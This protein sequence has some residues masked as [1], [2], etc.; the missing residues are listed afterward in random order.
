MT[1][2]AV[3]RDDADDDDAV[4]RATRQTP[5]ITIPR[6]DRCLCLCGHPLIDHFVDAYEVMKCETVGCGCIW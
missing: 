4:E 1:A 6:A 3:R 2:P 5:I